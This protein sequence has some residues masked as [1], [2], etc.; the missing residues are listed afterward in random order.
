MAV[1]DHTMFRISR[2]DEI[3]MMV[4]KYRNYR[5]TRQTTGVKGNEGRQVD[6]PNTGTHVRM[7]NRKHT[8]ITDLLRTYYPYF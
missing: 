4:M 3:A 7:E 6:T 2:R 1:T 8:L 5:L